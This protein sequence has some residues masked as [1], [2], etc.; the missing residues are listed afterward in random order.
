MSSME[1][2]S[3]SISTEITPEIIK[4]FT[5]DSEAIYGFINVLTEFI[6]LANVENYYRLYMSLN[7]QYPINLH[8]FCKFVPVEYR[9]ELKYLCGEFGSESYD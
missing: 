1:T 4:E 6:S 9:S 8:Q 7:E 2:V 3:K 5:E